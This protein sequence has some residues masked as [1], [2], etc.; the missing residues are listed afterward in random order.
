MESRL[1]IWECRRLLR[2]AAALEACSSS[3]A[4]GL[5][6][7]E[8]AKH[9]LLTCAVAALRLHSCTVEAGDCYNDDS[10]SGS[11]RSRRRAAYRKLALLLHPDKAPVELRGVLCLFEEAF[12]VLG[13]ADDLLAGGV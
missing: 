2:C 10:G 6:S 8:A 5:S 9:Q 4:A 3:M 7:P 12:K 13:K 1:K 11:M